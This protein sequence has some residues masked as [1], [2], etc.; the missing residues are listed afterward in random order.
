MF[1]LLASY[2]KF[3]RMLMEAPFDSSVMRAA[4]KG[5][6][7][8]QQLQITYMNTTQQW[9]SHQWSWRTSHKLKMVLTVS[10]YMAA[11][12]IWS[13]CYIEIR[14]VNLSFSTSSFTKLVATWHYCCA[15][16]MEVSE[17][18]RFQVLPNPKLKSGSPCD[19]ILSYSF[20]LLFQ[21][22][23]NCGTVC[24]CPKKL[25]YQWTF[26]QKCAGK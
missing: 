17:R 2:S 13:H 14:I 1:L 3:A 4:Y 8:S 22:Y 12:T 7:Q 9:P 25:Y 18:G 11:F 19:H 20:L 6:I 16:C 5:H 10:A 15:A 21:W 24:R 23:P 26:I